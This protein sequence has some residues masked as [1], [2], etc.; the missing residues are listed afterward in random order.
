[1]QLTEFANLL[2]LLHSYPC[3]FKII[4]TDDFIILRFY[5]PEIFMP[6]NQNY[7]TTYYSDHKYKTLLHAVY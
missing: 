6:Y 3:P 4:D 2:W 1:M 7:L 5:Y